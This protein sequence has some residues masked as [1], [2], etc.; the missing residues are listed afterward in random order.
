MPQTSRRRLRVSPSGLRPDR[1]CLEALADLHCSRRIQLAYIHVL[2]LQ[3]EPEP[4]VRV[5]VERESGDLLLAAIDTAGH[6][7]RH[8]RNDVAVETD[9]A[10]ARRQF[11]G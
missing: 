9:S 10:V 1:E 2:K 8:T 4:V 11:P 6:A 5:P 7:L 3:Y